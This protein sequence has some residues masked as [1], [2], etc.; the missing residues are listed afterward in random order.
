MS[1]KH[2]P[3]KPNGPKPKDRHNMENVHVQRI[4]G[5]KSQAIRMKKSDSNT[6]TQ[7]SMVKNT[8]RS[9]FSLRRA[10]AFEFVKLINQEVPSL[11]N[12]QLNEV[13]K[14]VGSVQGKLFSSDSRETKYE[15]QNEKLKLKSRLTQSKNEK[16][17]LQ[18]RL[19]HLQRIEEKV[20]KVTEK[21]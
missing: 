12:D 16:L 1:S 6:I 2:Y 5:I 3:T 8:H 17:K 15:F 13:A 19:N 20:I 4:S 7:T 9:H 21:T 11:S 10:S 14:I 18:S